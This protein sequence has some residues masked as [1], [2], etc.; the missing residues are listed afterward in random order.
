[1]VAR[2]RESGILVVFTLFVCASTSA[3]TSLIDQGRAALLRNDAETAVNLL[4]KAVA[5]SPNNAEAHDLLGNAY[6]TLAEHASI[7]KMPGLARKAHAEFERAVQL[8]PNYLDAR[9]AL[10]EFYML[11]PGFLGGSEEKAIAQANEIKKRDAIDGHRAFGLIYQH[12]KK[13]DLARK[14]YVDAVKE[15][16]NSPKARYWLGVSYYP[17]KNYKAAAIEFETAVRIDPSYMPGWFQIGHVAAL[18]GSDLD[19]GEE[20]LRKYLTY[21]PAHDE[22]PVYRAHY[23]LG[24]IY[25]KL[26]KK[27]EAKA[28]YATSLRL[29]SSQKDVAEALKRLS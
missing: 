4:E 18:S 11:A 17:D 7:F 13:P 15:Q 8:D 23:W 5:Q 1:M 19:R 21:T 27:S 20:A 25:E 26:G 3:Q 2:T 9:F 6:G 29:N 28:S 16:P 10:I 22:P 24:A 14:E 12:R